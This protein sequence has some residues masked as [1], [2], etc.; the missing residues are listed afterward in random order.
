LGRFTPDHFDTAVTQSCIAGGFSY[1]GQ[2]F[3]VQVTAKNAGGSNTLNYNAA[4]GLS[5]AVTLSAWD[6]TGTIA[7]PGPGNVT[8]TQPPAIIAAS[9]FTALDPAVALVSTP[10]Y[11]FTSRQTAPTKIRLRA[12]DTDAVSSATGSEGT[13]T[14]RSGRTS[15]SNAHGSELL[16]LPVPFRVEYWDGSWL[17][18]TDDTCTTGVTLALADVS[19]SDGLVPGETCVL[20]SGNPGISGIGCTAA[21][22]APKR[23]VAPTVAADFRLWLKAPGIG[24]SGALNLTATVPAWLQF[25]WKGIGDANP[26]ARVTFGV[27]AARKSPIIYMREN[28]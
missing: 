1:S 17:K 28:Y 15:L 3:T 26:S 23:F 21:G 19:V 14:V 8:P 25:N 9:A 12:T 7:S 11:T 4:T 22:I 24:N 6:D 10:A 13:T 27:N 2:P 20:D 16:D 5:K 18:N